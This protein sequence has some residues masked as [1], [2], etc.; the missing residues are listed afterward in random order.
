M[1]SG[2]DLFARYALP[3]N[4]LGYCGPGDPNEVHGALA[5]DDRSALRA[6]AREFEGAWPYLELIAGCNHLDDPLDVRVVEA[7]WVG[8]PLLRNVPAGALIAS[9]DDRFRRRA[10]RDWCGLPEAAARGGF[11]HHSFHVFAVY[12]WLGLL[13]A[14]TSGEPLHVL[15]RCRIRWG[16]VE[17]VEADRVLV[18]TRPLCFDGHLLTLGTPVVETAIPPVPDRA[19]TRGCLQPGD[20]VSLHWDWVCDRLSPVEATRLAL[21]TR[22]NLAVVNSLERPGPAEAC[23]RRVV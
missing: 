12:P 3:P 20:V 5:E 22:H 8:N 23:Q 17:E 7:Y 15:D 11:P 1:R 19:G 14:G 16:R 4:V 2:P 6:L 13:R 21:S 18:T 10:G 9:L